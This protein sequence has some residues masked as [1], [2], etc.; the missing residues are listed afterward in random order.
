M[1]LAIRIQCGVRQESSFHLLSSIFMLLVVP[2]FCRKR[3]CNNYTS[4]NGHDEKGFYFNS[5]VFYPVVWL[6]FSSF[7]CHEI[8][9]RLRQVFTGCN[10][11]IYSKYT[12][13]LISPRL[14]NFHLNMI[15][16][17][18][19]RPKEL[20]VLMRNCHLFLFTG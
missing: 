9:S 18:T 1:S 17:A 4:T 15:Q 2:C 7:S 11:Y 3:R 5:S 13:V 6:L 10:S 8:Y 19:K 16:C 14:F 12:G 20:F